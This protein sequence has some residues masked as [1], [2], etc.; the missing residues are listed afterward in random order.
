VTDRVTTPWTR[1]APVLTTG[2]IALALAA[3]LPLACSSDP[4]PSTPRPSAPGDSTARD[5]TG[6][7]TGNGVGGKPPDT[8]APTTTLAPP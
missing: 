7:T 2:A 5:V 6:A 3:G 8:F 4:G 1:R